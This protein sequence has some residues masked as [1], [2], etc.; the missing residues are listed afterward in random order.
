L[1]LGV[2]RGDLEMGRWWVFGLAVVLK[3]MLKQLL[4]RKVA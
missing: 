2:G 1:D 4:L 3:E